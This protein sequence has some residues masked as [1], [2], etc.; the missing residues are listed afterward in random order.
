MTLKRRTG[1]RTLRDFLD[2]FA[3]TA[4][5]VGL[6]PNKTPLPDQVDQIQAVLHLCP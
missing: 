6:K 3:S 5:A 2:R 4:Q 1:R